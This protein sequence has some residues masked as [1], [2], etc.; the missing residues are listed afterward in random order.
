MFGR[1]EGTEIYKAANFRYWRDAICDTFVD[2]DCTREDESPFDGWLDRRSLLDTR[3]V[4]V[5]ATRHMVSRDRARITRAGTD[6]ILLSI[7]LEGRGTIV[8][9]GREAVLGVGDF[10][11]YDTTMPYQFLLDTA[12][13][14]TCLRIQREEFCRRIGDVHKLTARTISGREG[15][16]RLASQFIR[17]LSTQLD[18]VGHAS[19]QP[20]HAT[21]LDLVASALGE[22]DG[23]PVAPMREARHLLLQR[24]LRFVE[25][26]L[27]R[28]DLS[29][30]E[31]A[32]AFAVSE[33]YLRKLFEDREQSLS[34]WIWHRRLEEARQRL[35][36]RRRVR[37]SVTSIAY[38]C[39]F[40]DVAHFSRAF[41]A[42]YGM[43]PRDFRNLG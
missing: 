30:E 41:R 40:K 39:G 21:M 31:V 3:F 2:L 26:H 14:Q 43:T 42:K 1:G 19:A 35:S 6:Y 27:D 36:D 22:L 15:T 25:D 8:Q 33:R 18:T 38:D 12:F 23:G 37:I 16:G 17:E 29:C 20:I 5:G 13:S 28:P 24:V 11:I 32:R 10:A 7:M 34:E 9:N 4:R